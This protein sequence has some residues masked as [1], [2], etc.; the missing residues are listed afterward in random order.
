MVA[1][2][3][4]Q[5]LWIFALTVISGTVWSAL[6]VKTANTSG[7]SRG[8]S[9]RSRTRDNTYSP[10]SPCVENVEPTQKE[11]SPQKSGHST[12]ESGETGLTRAT[13]ELL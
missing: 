7:E 11:A 8:G 13:D 6:L 12:K 5:D 10:A 4:D 1:L 9:Y 2:V 3:R